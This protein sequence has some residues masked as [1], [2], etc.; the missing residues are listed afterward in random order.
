MP[1]CRAKDAFGFLDRDLSGAW[2]LAEMVGAEAPTGRA[3]ENLMVAIARGAKGE[4][5]KKDARWSW[6]RGL[7]YV[8][9]PL[10]H[11]GRIWL[12]KAGGLVSALDAASGKPILD[13]ERLSDR[14]EYYMS[15]VGAGAHVLLGSS[16]G[17]FY[18]LAADAQ[19]L[20]VE[21]TLELGDELF[22]TPAVLDGTL[23]LRAKSTLW[24]FGK[25][26]K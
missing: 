2:E 20:V 23:Y 4:L 16:E 1:A 25:R 5:T 19:E 3:G 15:P 22:A 6:D 18:V 24:A 17:T 12:V 21:H 13:R 26:T 9:S 8:S 11:R 10:L 14:S 7:P